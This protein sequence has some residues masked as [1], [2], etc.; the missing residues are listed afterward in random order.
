MQSEL[1]KVLQGEVFFADWI[2]NFIDDMQCIELD[3]QEL[4]F[5]SKGDDYE[6]SESIC[7]G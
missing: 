2:E 1:T 3:D 4:T 5:L 7:D 6:K